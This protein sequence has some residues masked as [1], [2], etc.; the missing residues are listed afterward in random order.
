MDLFDSATSLAGAIRR[1]EISPVEVVDAYLARIDEA[2]PLINAIVWRNDD[3]VRAAAREAERALLAGGPLAPFHGV[4]IP[5]K[6]LSDVAG[7]PNTHSSLAIDATP[8]STTSL[9]VRKLQ[10][11]GFLLM[12]RT[13]S[14]ELG[15]LTVAENQRHGKTRNPWNPDYTPGGS[16]GGAAAAVAAGMAPVAHASDGGG[17][18]RVPSS[19][20]GLVG[21]KPSR[22][23]V[24]Q[25]VLAWE[26]S[27]VEGAITRTVADAAAVLDVMSEAD[28]LA[29]YSAP[30]PERPFAVEAGRDPRKTRIGVLLQAPTGLPVDPECI[31][32]AR[33]LAGALEAAGHEVFDVSPLLF[34]RE[35]I[36]AFQVIVSASVWATPFDDVSKVDPY[37]AHRIQQAEGFHAGLYAQAAALLQ[38]ESRRIVAQW[39]RDFDV[40]LTP[41]MATTTPPVGVVLDEANLDPA[42]PRLTELRMISFTSFCNMAGLPAISLPV[43]A[44][45]TGLP[46]GAQLV[47]APFGEGR[48]VALAAQAEAHFRWQEQLAPALSG[49]RP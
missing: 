29:W 36:D 10:D 30:A 48:L 47:G 40:L 24:P 44:A 9:S 5:I 14:P 34:S 12:G 31:E 7:Q 8:R 4:P 37:I 23:R 25:E 39:G 49:A 35:A 13:N 27:T 1:R 38:I 43:H 42:G 28:P 19:A 26:H 6:D 46:V 18:I 15:P 41:T 20:C 17:S 33:R 3:E 16:S 21:L 22:G 11:A 45:S 2:N 32:A